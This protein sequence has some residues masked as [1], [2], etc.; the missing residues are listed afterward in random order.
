MKT[1]ANPDHLWDHLSG[2][3][4]NLKDAHLKLR[5]PHAMLMV[6][7]RKLLARGMVILLHGYIVPTRHA[8]IRVHEWQKANQRN[9][10]ATHTWPSIKEMI[11]YERSMESRTKK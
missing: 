2:E 11:V 9:P 5:V 4:L 3:S 8:L 7:V 10:R 6:W 1:S